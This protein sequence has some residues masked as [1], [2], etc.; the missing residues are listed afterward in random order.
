MWTAVD[1][2]GENRPTQRKQ[3]IY[4]QLQHHSTH[5]HTTLLRDPLPSHSLQLAACVHS[6]DYLSFLER[7]WLEWSELVAAKQADTYMTAEMTRRGGDTSVFLPGQIAPR[8][9]SNVVTPEAAVSMAALS[10]PGG[11]IHSQIC[12]YAL[13]RLTPIQAHTLTDLAHDLRVIQTAAD[14]IPPAS[15]TAATTA[16]TYVYALTTQPGHHAS[17]ST[18]GG[19]C[20]IATAAV[21]AALLRQKGYERVGVLDIDYHA[22]NGTIQIYY[23]SADV[24]VASLHAHPDIVSRPTHTHNYVATQLVPELAERVHS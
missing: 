4:D 18:F 10:R 23:G 5:I 22:G 8:D 14:L 1:G 11:S 24:M 2:L 17:T 13:D 7:A 3:L 21:C 9:S 12:Y 20:Y 16:A 6:A 15:S 19:Y